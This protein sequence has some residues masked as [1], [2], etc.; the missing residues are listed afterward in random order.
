MS[1][2]CRHPLQLTPHA[3]Q[4]LDCRICAACFPHR[5]DC[6]G[7]GSPECVERCMNGG[8][9]LGTATGAQQEIDDL[10]SAYM[11]PASDRSAP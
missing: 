9:P 1:R 8:I 2:I 6:P 7:H 4:W 11:L 3:P 10:E 5:D